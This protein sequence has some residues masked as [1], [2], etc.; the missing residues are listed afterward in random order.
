[1]GEREY[2]AL[3]NALASACMEGLPVMEET[4]RDLKRLLNKEIS[5]EYLVKEIMKQPA[6]EAD[7]WQS[8]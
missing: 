4:E 3:R 1:M 8:L 2:E 6:K 7:I 5:V